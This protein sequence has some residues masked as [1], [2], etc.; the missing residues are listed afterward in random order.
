MPITPV[1]LR[2]VTSRSEISERIA[3]FLGVQYCSWLYSIYGS[4]VGSR[5]SCWLVCF[6]APWGN[7]P[8]ISRMIK[9]FCSR[10]THCI[11]FHFHWTNCVCNWTLLNIVAFFEEFY[12]MRIMDKVIPNDSWEYEWWW[13]KMRLLVI[14]YYLVKLYF[15]NNL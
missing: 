7:V 2:T 8:A 11:N 3:R 13:M 1:V 12:G 9:Y 10:T 6:L 5:W 4:I 15:L 14:F